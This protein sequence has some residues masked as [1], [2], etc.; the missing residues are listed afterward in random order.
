MSGAKGRV[1]G[2]VRTESQVSGLGA[3]GVLLEKG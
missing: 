3:E 1:C 2:A